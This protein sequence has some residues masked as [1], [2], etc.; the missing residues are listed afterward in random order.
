MAQNHIPR[1]KDFYLNTLNIEADLLKKASDLAERMM[2]AFM[3]ENKVEVKLD[4]D[5]IANKI[6]AK[7]MDRLPQ[8]GSYPGSYPGSQQGSSGGFKYDDDTPVILKTEKIEIKGKTGTVSKSG[9]SISD[10]MDILD[11]LSI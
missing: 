8:Q 4:V 10:N 3:R 6:I 7:I 9:D 11:G 2:V 5:D 1:N